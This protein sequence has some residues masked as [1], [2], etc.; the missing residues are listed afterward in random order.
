MKASWL[1]LKQL[2]PGLPDDPKVLAEKFTHAGVEVESQHAFGA[3][4]ETCVVCWVV[5]SRPHPSKS[6]LKLVTVDRGGG[7][8]QEVVCGAPNVPEAGGI[9]VLAPLGAYLPAK[10]M[11]IARREIAGV[12]SEGMLCSEAELGLTDDASGIL[13]LPPGTAEPGVRFI[14]AVP[15]ARDTVFEIGLTPNRP[16]G[17]GHLGLAREAAALFG[18]AWKVPAPEKPLKESATDA[19]HMIRVDIEDRERC[20]HYGAAVVEDVTIGPSPLSIRYRLSAL[21]VRPISNAVDVTNIVL[22]EYGHPMHAFDLDRVRGGRIVVRRAK[23]KEKLT[24]LDGIERV[25]TNDDLLICDGEGPVALAG[26]MGGANSEINDKTKRILLECAYFDPRTVRRTSRRHGLHSESSHRFERGIDWGDTRDALQHAAA[27]TARLGGGKVSRGIVMN[28]AKPLARAKVSLRFDRLDQLLGV[29]VPPNEGEAILVRLGFENSGKEW[30]VPSHRPDVSREVDLI[31][32]IARV[33]GMASIPTEIPA[34]R[35]TDDAGPKETLLRDARHAALELGL[36]EALVYAFTSPKVLADARAKPAEVLLQNPLSVEQSV[37]RT[38]LRPGLLEAVS[39]AR[40]HGERN[41]QLFTTGAIYE[42]DVERMSFAA[43]LA[44]DR[45]TWLAKPQPLSVWDAKGLA[46]G[47]VRRLTG[48]AASVRAANIDH[49]HPRGAAEVLVGD[50]VV[51]ALG[52]VHPE[53]ADAMGTGPDVMVLELDLDALAAV[54]KRA[55]RYAAI[56]R[57][58]ATLRDIAVVVK[59]TVP[60]GDVLEAARQSA[61]PLA[62]QIAIFDRFTGG[63]VPAGSV[64]L[65]LRLVYRSA[66]RTLT[67]A[68]VDAAHA[69][70]VAALDKRFGATLRA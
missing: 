6:A 65:A 41:V 39:R 45:E 40:R 33:R 52:P 70:V 69:N 61:G 62:E 38:S 37:M 13:V 3:G 22:L 19:S 43:I 35:P 50:H 20:P 12:A 29:H 47:L 25:L 54:G 1:W 26:V 15:Q 17:L 21:G 5:S 48:D 8:L 9:V 2:V 66:E 49:L 44:G 60:A 32:E 64:S 63:S 18:I 23:D 27:M 24:T 7:T 14:D 51:G 59:E 58:P 56:P 16:D 53:I 31:E 28:D 55:P 68:E 11:T 36:S 34:I 42:K 10:N 57:F 4:S 67:D 30:T 46:D